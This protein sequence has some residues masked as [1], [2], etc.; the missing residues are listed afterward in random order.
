MTLDCSERTAAVGKQ[1]VDAVEALKEQVAAFT[2]QVAALTTQ[3]TAHQTP[4][5]ERPKGIPKN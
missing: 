5:S 4:A 2:E 3:Q 1:Q